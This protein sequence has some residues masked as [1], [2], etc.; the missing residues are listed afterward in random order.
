M[1]VSD[2][3]EEDQSGYSDHDSRFWNVRRICFDEWDGLCIRAEALAP[4]F[5]E[6]GIL[7]VRRFILLWFHPVSEPAL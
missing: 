6:Q 5:K 3:D 1:I 7:F 2:Q 4:H